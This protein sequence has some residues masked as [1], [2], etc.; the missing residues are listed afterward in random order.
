MQRARTARS[1]HSRLILYPLTVLD[2]PIVS[3][4]F[5]AVDSCLVEHGAPFSRCRGSGEPRLAFGLLD[6]PEYLH[7]P[8]VDRNGAVLE[9]YL[10]GDSAGAASVV[11]DYLLVSER[12]TVAA[13]AHQLP[14]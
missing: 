4:A 10:A 2:E 9:L 1:D 12:T 8:Y 11:D 7:R 6:D 5:E 13:Y 14:A 3:V